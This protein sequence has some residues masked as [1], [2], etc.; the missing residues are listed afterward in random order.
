MSHITN[1]IFFQKYDIVFYV[2]QR[3]MVQEILLEQIYRSF[4]QI[5]RSLY[6]SFFQKVAASI[7]KI[8]FSCVRICCEIGPDYRILNCTS[9]I[10][11][12]LELHRYA[13]L[14][15]SQNQCEN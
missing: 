5:Y 14:C 6:F 7:K 9:I 10:F 8:V 1:P 11:I 3:I 12:K 2:F 15:N 4:E 13:H